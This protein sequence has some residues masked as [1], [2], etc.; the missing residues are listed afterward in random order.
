M[1]RAPIL[2]VAL[3]LAGGAIA[4]TQTIH[5]PTKEGAGAKPDSAESRR[6]QIPEPLGQN[7]PEAQGG[8]DSQ[9]NREYGQETRPE[10]KKLHEGTP[11]A[12]KR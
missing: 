7:R 9:Q 4:Q 2:A 11:A 6:E 8:A 1:K 12:P 10:G 3:V 5:P